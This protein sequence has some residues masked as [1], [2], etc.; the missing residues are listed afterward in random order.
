MKI[1]VFRVIDQKRIVD[2][3]RHMMSGSAFHEH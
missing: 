1:E 3:C 2:D